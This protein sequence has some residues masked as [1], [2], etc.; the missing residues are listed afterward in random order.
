MTLLMQLKNKQE[1]CSVE[2]RICPI[3][4]F[5]DD[6]ATSK[7]QIAYFFSLCMREMAIFQLPV[8]NLTSP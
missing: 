2:H 6:S 3:A 7:G 8:K 5:I 1:I 4:K